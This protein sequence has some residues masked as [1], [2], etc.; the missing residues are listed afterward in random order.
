VNFS[1]P[2]IIVIVLQPNIFKD[3]SMQQPPTSSN[4]CLPLVSWGG[5]ELKENIYVDGKWWIE[6]YPPSLAIQMQRKYQPLQIYKW[7]SYSMLL[8]VLG[9]IYN[10]SLEHHMH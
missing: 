3:V 7:N 5:L 1:R 9:I 6:R 8:R 4:A 10:R 2:W